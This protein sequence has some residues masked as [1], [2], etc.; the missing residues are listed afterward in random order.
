MPFAQ[1][2]QEPKQFADPV[3]VLQVLP[4]R[5]LIRQPSPSLYIGDTDDP[6]QKPT[7]PDCVPRITVAGT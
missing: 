2:L 4:V 7:Y 6:I 5:R 3:V 1:Q